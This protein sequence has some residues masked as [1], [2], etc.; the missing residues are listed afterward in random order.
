MVTTESEFSDEDY[1]FIEDNQLGTP[2]G[3]YRLK[4]SYI[5]LLRGVGLFIFLA[6]IASL[7]ITISLALTKR[8][9]SPSVLLLP[10]LFGSFYALFH[11]GVFYRIMAQ[12][13]QSMRI[14]V[15]NDGLLKISKK[16]KRNR[17]E[18][19]RW[20]DISTISKALIGREYVVTCRNEKPFTQLTLSSYF[21]KLDELVALI[22]EGIEQYTHPEKEI[23]PSL[24]QE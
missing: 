4:S 5:R 2:L 20:K 16:M 18:V 23:W 1:Q 3:I 9:D 17:V 13:A 11:G 8:P 6:G 19:V 21:Q 12:Q 24:S 15:C 14:I 22:T 10:P 7:V